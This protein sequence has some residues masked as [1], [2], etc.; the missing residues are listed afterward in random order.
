MAL[1]FRFVVAYF[2]PNLDLVVVHSLPKWIW[3]M[4][5][6]KLVHATTMVQTNKAVVVEQEVLLLMLMKEN[7]VAVVEVEEAAAAMAYNFGYP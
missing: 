7:W 1:V 3:M 6:W 4:L 2:H 5:V